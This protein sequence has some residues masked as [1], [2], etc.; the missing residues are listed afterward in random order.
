[1]LLLGLMAVLTVFVSETSAGG[2]GPTATVNSVGN[3]DTGPLDF[4]NCDT[5]PASGT[6][7][8]REAINYANAGHVDI[9]DF[10]PPVFSK[11]SPGVIDIEG[12][13]QC[14]PSIE[15]ELT[16]DSTD[17][18]VILDGDQDD[19]GT[20]ID[21][22]D[23]GVIDVDA[24]NNGF[25]FTLNGGKNFVIREFG[26]ETDAIQLDGGDAA[27]P[28]GACTFGEVDI[29]GVVVEGG[30]FDDGIQIANTINLD[31][32]SVTNNDVSAADHAIWMRADA[33]LGAGALKNNN[34]LVSGNSLFGDE[35]DEGSGDGVEIELVGDL[36]GKITVQVIENPVITSLGDDAV[37][38]VDIDARPNGGDAES[39]SV[40]VDVQVNGNGLSDAE[41]D[42]GVEIEVEVCC[43]QSQHV[44]SITVDG[45]DDIIGDDD[46][47]HIAVDLCCGDENESTVSASGNARLEG[48]G[49]DA[50][51][52]DVLV[53]E[54]AEGG[55]G[56]NESD[57]N[58]SAI[59]VNGNGMLV[60]GGSNGIEIEADVGHDT[61]SG[62]DNE[63]IVEVLDNER[64]KG[65][66]HGVEVDTDAGS[67]SGPDA[68]N[69]HAIVT[70]AGNGEIEG[71]GDDGIDINADTGVETGPD[72][73]PGS[74][75]PDG[76]GTDGDENL[77]EV[78]VTDNGEIDGGDG[79]GMDV[80]VQAGG[81]SESS[82]DNHTVTVITG[83][84]QILSSGDEGDEGIDYE[85]DVCCDAE[86]T[87][88]LTVSENGNITAFDGDGVETD[89][90][91]SVNIVTIT[92]NANIRGNDGNGIDIGIADES[93]GD[94]DPTEPCPQDCGIWSS[95]TQL[96]ITGN[97]IS[98]S[99]NDGIDVDG[100]IFQL[101][102][103]GIK[104]V[105]A[106]N[107]IHHNRDHGI[108]LHSVVGMW[109]GPANE[110]HENGD[111]PDLDAGVEIDTDRVVIQGHPQFPG[112]AN[113]ITQNS[114]HDNVG[115]G[116]RLQG[117]EDL[118]G[119][120]EDDVVDDHAVGCTPFAM[121]TSP[122]ICL[123]MPDLVTQAGD[124]L[125]GTACA[126][127]LVEVFEADGDPSGYGEGETFL[128]SGTAD[129]FGDFSIELPCDLGAVDLTATS[130]DKLK[131]T[132][133][134]SEN[135]PTLGTS[136]C[137]P[138]T[139]TITETPLPVDTATPAP[140][141]ATAEP[142]ADTATPEPDNCGD[143]NDDGA[144]DSVDASLILQLKAGL[145]DSLPKAAAAD[146]NGD[147][148]ITSVDAALLLQFSAGLIP[149]LSC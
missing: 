21:C 114:I 89:L 123:P 85:A 58:S 57:G 38:G 87:N 50:V 118:D 9:I 56:G 25:D 131:N 136:V 64:I 110:I 29:N 146:V 94:A 132:S 60:G 49:S 107:V 55:G 88:T 54:V 105:I 24:T 119:L 61:G 81:G 93:D 51:D 86:N 12:G 138:P 36:D 10:H 71:D 72:D 26:I 13:S 14:L 112:D 100:G 125:I 97:D 135:L 65:E 53:G 17:T 142:P 143:V 91:C 124:K 121:G 83:N 137:A 63:S 47:V 90:C 109:I 84:E 147:G 120:D 41:D 134:F 78:N 46:A 4:G 148:E 33:G 62:D 28:C 7:N 144:V 19:D 68:D 8:L 34:V 44:S 116:I 52:I 45:N 133:E 103:A 66:D 59:M 98:N 40:A 1:M 6:C 37:Q 2:V 122:N 20:P 113:T 101:E 106:N 139:P 16:I 141:T 48:Q 140:P 145:I 35:D 129:E 80:E 75:D 31:S 76:N 79:D 77:T 27:A 95:V 149:S 69:N 102:A 11:A 127:C 3:L 30:E 99:E 70:I 130:T 111:D 22:P 23:E 92:D 15:V 117:D 18:G 32:I 126:D 73:A 39:G 74:N 115:L 82:R 96:T 104:S 128:I 42:D 5:T 67:Q 43:D 108:E